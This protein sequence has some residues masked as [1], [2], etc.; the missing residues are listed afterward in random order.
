MSRPILF[1]FILLFFPLL[2]ACGGAA[3]SAPTQQTEA[4]S[5]SG[6]VAVS[7]K[8]ETTETET[9]GE[10][11]LQASIATTVGQFELDVVNNA[12]RMLYHTL[13]VLMDEN[14]IK[15]QLSDYG[16]DL[17]GEVILGADH[18]SLGIEIW[19][20][21]SPPMSGGQAYVVSSGDK[22]VVAFRSTASDDGWEATLNVLTDIKAYPKKLSF[23]DDSAPDAKSYKNL[24]V[25]S[26]FHNEYLRYRERILE[27]VS[28][29]PEKDIYVTGHSLGGALA[30]LNA[31][32]IAAHTQRLVT[33]FT[34]GQPRVGGAKFRKAY[35]ALVPDTYRVVLDGDP[36]ARVPGLFL[37][38]EHV[39]KLLQFDSDGSQL[40]PEDIRSS[41]YFET[42][43]FPKHIQQAYHGAL[44]Q[45]H[46]SCSGTETESTD[47]GNA[48]CLNVGWLAGAADAERKAAKSAWDAV[49]E[50]SIPWEG[51]PLGEITIEKI[52]VDSLPT[53]FPVIDMPAWE[54]MISAGDILI[55]N[56]P[57]D[58]IPLDKIP[59]D[60]LPI[61]KIPLDKLSKKAPKNPF[62]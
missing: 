17:V 6:T 62:K 50:G 18:E 39:G 48:G 54:K 55:D 9:G 56:V 47:Q 3:P 27:Y 37:E 13:W 2:L 61:D 58:K 42:F 14:V 46:A 34:F 28:Q 57:I 32:D 5:S 59:V 52:P 8:V 38:Y 44:Q 19:G 23:I 29:Q 11:A 33:V 22:I 30:V 40:P 16:F 49:P 7:E 12:T 45:L 36:I 60:K 20:V 4:D 24:K 25:H 31:F 1:C 10:V 41:P 51:I 26:G 53:D 15:D 35:E 21:E 43:D